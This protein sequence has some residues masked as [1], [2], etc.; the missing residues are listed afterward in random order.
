MILFVCL[1]FFVGGFTLVL[2]CGCFCF[3]LVFA[4]LYIHSFFT[5]EYLSL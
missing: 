5:R 3:V 1:G 4:Y 2:F